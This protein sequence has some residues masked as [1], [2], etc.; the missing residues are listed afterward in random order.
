MPITSGTAVILTYQFSD[1]DGR[2]YIGSTLVQSGLIGGGNQTV[3]PTTTTTYTLKVT[4]MANDSVT[5]DLT[6][7]VQ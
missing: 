1:G 7:T 2:L 6:V 4:N 5:Q 3:H